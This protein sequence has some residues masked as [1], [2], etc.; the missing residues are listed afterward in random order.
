MFRAMF[1]CAGVRVAGC[2]AGC[3]CGCDAGCADGSAD[4]FARVCAGGCSCDLVSGALH[5]ED[6]AAIG[7]QASWLRRPTLK[8]LRIGQCPLVASVKC[9]V[10]C[11]VVLMSVSVVLP[12]VMLVI[13]LVVALVVVLVQALG[14]R[15][16]RLNFKAVRALAAPAKNRHQSSCPDHLGA[17]WLPRGKLF[18]GLLEASWGLGGL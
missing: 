17:S 7:A 10:V 2:A 1:D 16:W 11:L 5:S 6:C 4:G 13:V 12:L 9:I 15:C 3:V 18:G 14:S 8:K